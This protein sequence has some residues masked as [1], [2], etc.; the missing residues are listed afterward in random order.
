MLFLS[1]LASTLSQES[2][3]WRQ[4]TVLLLDGVSYHKSAPTRQLFD[5]LGI[6]VILL[7]PY[8]YSGAPVELF[9][10][11]LKKANLNPE[12]LQTGKR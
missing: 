10:G 2:K 7:S 4:N 5:D 9:F 6:K 3:D 8:S 11:Y 1:K 12:S